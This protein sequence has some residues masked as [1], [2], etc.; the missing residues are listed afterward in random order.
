ML[1]ALIKRPLAFGVLLI[2]IITLFYMIGWGFEKEPSPHPNI[3]GKNDHDIVTVTGKVYQIQQ[4]QEK[5]I[6]YISNQKSKTI[7][8]H[9]SPKDISIGNVIQA[10]GS[11]TQFQTA[12]NPGNFN[13]Q[14]YNYKQGIYAQ[15]FA[16]KLKIIDSNVNPLLHALSRFRTTW[17][18]RLLSELGEKN[19]NTLAAVILGDQADMDSDLKELYQKNGI[20]HI[21]A[22]SGL[23]ISFI[24]LLGY[25]LLRHMGLSFQ[26]SGFMGITILI[27]YALMVGLTISTIRAVT[28]FVVRVGADITGRVYDMLTSLSIAALMVIIFKPMYLKDSGFLLSFGA[29]L[30]IIWV[31]PFLKSWIPCKFKWMDGF[32]ASAAIN[33][34]LFPLILYFYFEFP[35]YSFLLNILVIPLMSLLLGMGVLGLLVYPLVVLPGPLFIKGCGLILDVYQGLCHVAGKLPISRWVTGKP[36]IWQIVVYYVILGG[37]IVVFYQYNWLENHQEQVREKIAILAGVVTAICVVSLHPI[38]DSSFNFTM[39]DVGQGDGIYL[40]SPDGRDYFFDGGSSDIKQVGKYRIEPYLKCQGVGNLEYVFISHGD[41]DHMNGIEEML[42]R[43]ELGV[44][45]KRV[46]IAT[47]RVQDDALLGLVETARNN[48]VKVYVMG[49]KE[50]MD[51]KV[52]ITCIQPDE[53]YEGEIGNASSMILSVSYKDLSILLTGD[54]EGTGMKELEERLGNSEYKKELKLP[55][56]YQILKVPHHGSRNGTTEKLLSQVQPV[57]SLIS[58]GENNSYGHPHKETVKRLE[59]VESRIESTQEHGAITIK[60]KKGSYIIAPWSSD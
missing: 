31:Y 48:G 45:I 35:L 15:V 36:A 60:R 32:Y 24:G 3:E 37:I 20:G 30:G 28:M 39:L 38:R 59:D 2:L 26:I 17:K 14:Y 52:S 1:K 53:A 21:L 46:V 25:K 23:H 50:R 41:A 8:Y 27:L 57:L 40:H 55:D 7:I 12:R 47:E 49:A 5:Q 34:V 56:T 19:G 58:A 11:L 33:I 6:I 9:S 22:I 16:K 54:V 51:G 13:Q 44:R 4:K 10:T 43:Q 42:K 29:I 18:N